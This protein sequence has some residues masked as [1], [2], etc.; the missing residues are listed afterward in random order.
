MKL[1]VG[2]CVN[3]FELGV[4]RGSPEQ[5]AAKTEFPPTC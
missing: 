2:F 5:V 1:W 4:E 3:R